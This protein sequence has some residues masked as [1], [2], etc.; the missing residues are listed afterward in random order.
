MV[1]GNWSL[2]S[3]RFDMTDFTT[4]LDEQG[5]VK[6]ITLKGNTIW[7]D[8]KNRNEVDEQYLQEADEDLEYIDAHPEL[9]CY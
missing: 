6:F 9:F 4:F 7:V 1:N 5:L 2:P 3:R 8:P